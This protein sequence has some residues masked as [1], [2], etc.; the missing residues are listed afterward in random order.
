MEK[1]P[2]PQLIR[3]CLAGDMEAAEALV[4]RYRQPLY[5]FLMYMLRNRTDADDLFQEVWLHVF[6]SLERYRHRDRFRSWLF[7]IAHNLVIDRARRTRPATSLDAPGPDG[8]PLLDRLPSRTDPPGLPMER[9]EIE[10]SIREAVEALPPE[11]R[12]VFV[13]RTASELSFR[14][15]ARLQG[16]SINTALGRMHYAV[17]KLRKALEPDGGPSP[18]G[19][20]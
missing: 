17:L 12:E 5:G 13:L 3:A 11:Q 7:R 19:R 15:I 14:E 6:R 1:L 4:E 9:E 2:D 18:G 20:K 10:A 16:T 8:F